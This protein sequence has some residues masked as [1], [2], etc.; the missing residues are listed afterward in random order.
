MW[1]VVFLYLC[2]QHIQSNATFRRYII[3]IVF[4]GLAHS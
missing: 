3:Q 2:P 1:N 4:T